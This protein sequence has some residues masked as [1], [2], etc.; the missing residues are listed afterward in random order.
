MISNISW[1]FGVLAY[2]LIEKKENEKAIKVID[3]Y[4][5]EYPNTIVPYNEDVIYL[6]QKY[7]E[8]GEFKK[9]NEIGKQILENMKLNKVHI[10]GLFDKYNTIEKNEFVKNKIKEASEKY[11]QEEFYKGMF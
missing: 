11:K 9:A 6:L 4:F 8:L 1:Q 5:N 7:Y 2:E 3:K 10:P